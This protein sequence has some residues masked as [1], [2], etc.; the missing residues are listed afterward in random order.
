MKKINFLIIINIIII[1]S[2]ITYIFF[3][4]KE[5]ISNNNLSLKVIF[6]P[7]IFMILKYNYLIK[8]NSK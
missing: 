6:T 2:F 7:L 4:E 3:D 5:T 8:I 1:L